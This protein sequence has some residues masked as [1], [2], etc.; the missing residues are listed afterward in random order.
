MFVSMIVMS[1]YLLGLSCK[2]K[3]DFKIVIRDVKGMK[4]EKSIRAAKI[5]VLAVLS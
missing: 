2:S 5:V 3:I 1:E 4:A